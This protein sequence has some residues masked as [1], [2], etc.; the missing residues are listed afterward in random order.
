MKVGGSVSWRESGAALQSMCKEN[1]CNW[2]AVYELSSVGTKEAQWDGALTQF[3][4]GQ[5]TGNS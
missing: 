4:F 5:P 3:P 2:N 1:K